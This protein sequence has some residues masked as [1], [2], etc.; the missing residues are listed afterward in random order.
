M[1][2]QAVVS[3]SAC[4]SGRAPARNEA[5]SSSLPGLAS[6]VTS[7]PTVTIAISSVSAG[8]RPQG[9]Q[10]HAARGREADEPYAESELPSCPLSVAVARVLGGRHVEARWSCACPL[11]PAWPAGRRGGV[12][13]LFHPPLIGV[14]GGPGSYVVP[15]RWW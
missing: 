14:R 6:S 1:A 12:A 2:N 9:G 3:G 15:A 7:S 10:V 11:P 13:A 5:S 8:I 4:A